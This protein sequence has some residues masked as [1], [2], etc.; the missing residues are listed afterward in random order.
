MIP[1][2]YST[3]QQLLAHRFG[4]GIAEDRPTAFV[5]RTIFQHVRYALRSNTLQIFISSPSTNSLTQITRPFTA[6]DIDPDSIMGSSSSGSTT[7]EDND[8]FPADTN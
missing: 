3:S 6:E 1:I 7:E 2:T 4:L 5:F 8:L